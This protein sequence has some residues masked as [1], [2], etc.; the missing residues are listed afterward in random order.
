MQCVERSLLP[1]AKI[2]Q[3]MS[4]CYNGYKVNNNNIYENELFPEKF[5]GD[6]ILRPDVGLVAGP[7]TSIGR[8]TLYPTTPAH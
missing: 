1:K 7:T 2:S 5:V 8:Y 4:N 6:E 3:P